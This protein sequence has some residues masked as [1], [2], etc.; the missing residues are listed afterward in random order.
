MRQTESLRRF[1][2]AIALAMALLGWPT[3]SRA[4][5]VTG[6][7]TAAQA[8]VIGPL[9]TTTTTT[10]S[11]TGTLGGTNDASDASLFTASVPSLLDGEVLSAETIGYPDEVNAEATLACCNPRF[12]GAGVSAD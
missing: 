11:D 9:G 7:A 8:T 12:G 6:Q 4:Q 2:I 3:A 10:L 5:T 1:L